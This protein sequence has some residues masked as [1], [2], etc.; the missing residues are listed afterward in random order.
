MQPSCLN[1]VTWRHA[2]EQQF[3]RI[4]WFTD[5]SHAAWCPIEDQ[6]NIR[7]SIICSA[8]VTYA[9]NQHF[10]SSINPFFHADEPQDSCVRAERHHQLYMLHTVLPKAICSVL[11]YLAAFIEVSCQHTAIQSN[12]H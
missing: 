6:H 4:S 5:T 11:F 9:D 7:R 8:T 2:A 3:I 1:D 12:S 10:N